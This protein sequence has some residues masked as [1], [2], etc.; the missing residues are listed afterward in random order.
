MQKLHR[1]VLK[2]PPP[3]RKNEKERFK[4]FDV[5]TACCKSLSEKGP[6]KRSCVDL[7]FHFVRICQFNLDIKY[8][9]YADV[10]GH[11][12]VERRYSMTCVTLACER[13]WCTTKWCIVSSC[14]VPRFDWLG[15]AAAGVIDC[16]DDMGDYFGDPGALYIDGTYQV[17]K[18][19]PFQ[20]GKWAVPLDER[21][22]E[23]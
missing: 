21:F 18:W 5:G 6:N 13:P 15:F 12:N 22:N 7:L 1:G 4:S 11:L 9:C 8:S 23:L 19:Q 10:A 2:I 20:A 14:E 3:P 17:I 16:D